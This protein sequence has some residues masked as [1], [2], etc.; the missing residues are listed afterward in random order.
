MG[1]ST[2]SPELRICCGWEVA[3]WCWLAAEP[4]GLASVALKPRCC[5]TVGELH[6]FSWLGETGMRELRVT[7]DT[8][9]HLLPLRPVSKEPSR[10][11]WAEGALAGL[12][13]LLDVEEVFA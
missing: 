2:A 13:A 7:L 12:F 11:C 8:M 5:T 4:D 3:E 9:E 1:L 6:L 10:V